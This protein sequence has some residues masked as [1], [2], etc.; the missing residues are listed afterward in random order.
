ME[1]ICKDVQTEPELLPEVKNGVWSPVEEN[2]FFDIQVCHLN[3]D[4]SPGGMTPECEQLNKL[5]A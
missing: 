1:K 3:A 5:L 2:T 4:S